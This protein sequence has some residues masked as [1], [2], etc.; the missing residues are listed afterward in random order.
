LV[1][2]DFKNHPVAFFLLNL[3]R[4]TDKTRIEFFAYSTIAFEDDYTRSIKN[5]IR[6]WQVLSRESDLAAAKQIHADGIHILID[7]AGHTGHGRL[8]IF[9]FKPAPIQVSWLGYFSTTGLPEMDYVLVDEIGVPERD[10]LQFTERIRYLPETRLCFT[11]PETAPAVDPSPVLKNKHITFGCYQNISK[12]N[13]QVL[14]CWGSI[15]SALPNA[16][17]RWQCAQFVDAEARKLVLNRLGRSG[18]SDAKFQLLDGTS[19]QDYLDSYRNVDMV[20]DTF[21][22]PGGTTTCEALWMGVPTLTLAGSNFL[23]RQGASILT[24]AGLSNWVTF[25]GVDYEMKAIEFAN[26]LVALSQLR[27]KLRSMVAP[28]AL[29]DGARFARIFEM[30]IWNIW[31]EAAAVQ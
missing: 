19:R 26:D 8:P 18:I 23:S 9:S 13:D 28:T 16:K 3:L 15:L 4:H 10:S 17:L 24:A 14:K 21:P 12:V 30:T 1:S 6:S 29:F 5:E 7:L 22:F 25:S 20:L 2:G 27:M 31:S 11:P